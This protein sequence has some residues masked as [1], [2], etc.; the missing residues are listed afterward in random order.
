[1]G[2]ILQSLAGICLFRQ[3]PQDLPYAPQALGAAVL[4]SG[5]L[6]YIAAANMPESGNVGAQVLAAAGFSLLFLYAVLVLRALQARFMQSATALFG[7]E[8]LI[9]IPLTVL[10]FML[11]GSDPQSAPGAATAILLLWAWRVGI[12]GH[13]F[14][15]TLEIPLALGVLLALA[16]SF[17][18]IQVVYWV[19]G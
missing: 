4:L 14:R 11:A 13:I 6:N 19:G 16:Y 5:A 10:S 17:L 9:A 12:V 7:T 2:S 1:M 3:G 18:S 15:H 8:V